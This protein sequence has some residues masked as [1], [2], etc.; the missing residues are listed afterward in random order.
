MQAKSGKCA[1][2]DGRLGSSAGNHDEQSRFARQVRQQLWQGE[3][4]MCDGKMEATCDGE[5]EATHEV[6]GENATEKDV[7]GE[8]HQLV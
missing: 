8:G 2:V 1:C 4:A 5:M 3:L 6:Q 7:G